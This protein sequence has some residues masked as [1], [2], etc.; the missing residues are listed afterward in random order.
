V[1]N[2]T[3]EQLADMAMDRIANDRNHAGWIGKSAV[4]WSVLGVYE[5]EGAEAAF[6][7]V[8][9]A[10]IP[11]IRCYPRSVGYSGHAAQN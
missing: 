4:Y 6:R 8:S 1:N 5:R 3:V 9:D 11:Q 2:F 7:Y 10:K